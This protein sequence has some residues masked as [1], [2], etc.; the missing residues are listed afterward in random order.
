MTGQNPLVPGLPLPRQNPLHR[1][2]APPQ[3]TAR[4]MCPRFSYRALPSR[5][6]GGLCRWRPTCRSPTASGC[7]RRGTSGWGPLCCVTPQPSAE[8][9][10]E[11]LAAELLGEAF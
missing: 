6:C 5:L 7:H 11:N 2:G 9:A 3:P 10:G 1:K 8:S 4:P